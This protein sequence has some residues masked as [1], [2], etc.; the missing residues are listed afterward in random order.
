MPL[1]EGVTTIAVS[2]DFRAILG[3]AARVR[4]MTMQRYVDIHLQRIIRE[5]MHGRATPSALTHRGQDRLPPTLPLPFD[6][7]SDS[8]LNSRRDHVPRSI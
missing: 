6:S 3:V 2:K 1:P 5:D 4:G 8:T 7:D